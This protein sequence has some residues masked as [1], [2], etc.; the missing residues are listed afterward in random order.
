MRD[1]LVEYIQPLYLQDQYID[2]TS[3]ARI[4]Y[5]YDQIIL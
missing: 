5:M 3:A 1:T 4:I 2:C